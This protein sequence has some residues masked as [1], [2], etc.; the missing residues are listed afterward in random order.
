M[1]SPHKPFAPNQPHD[2]RAFELGREQGLAEHA[3]RPQPVQNAAC[4]PYRASA[5]TMIGIR[6]SQ[7]QAEIDGLRHL[8]KFT[9][10]M[11][12][13]PADEYLWKLIVG[14]RTV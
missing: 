14:Q 1:S 2:H 4:M 10:A 12:G 13:T 7:L 9:E 6:I 5:K 8:A 3:D 11:E